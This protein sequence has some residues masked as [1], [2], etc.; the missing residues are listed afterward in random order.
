MCLQ[1]SQHHVTAVTDLISLRGISYICMTAERTEFCVATHCRTYPASNSTN[2]SIQPLNFGHRITVPQTY[3]SHIYCLP[4]YSLV[5]EVMSYVH[6][7]STS[8]SSS[9]F[10]QPSNVCWG[11]LMTQSTS[12]SHYAPFLCFRSKC[13]PPTRTLLSSILDVHPL[14]WKTMFRTHTELQAD[15][16]R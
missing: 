1:A 12:S 7:D 3:A 10:E 16:R 14:I 8:T 9:C 5:S 6:A 15:N 13:P 2:T 11:L 4:L